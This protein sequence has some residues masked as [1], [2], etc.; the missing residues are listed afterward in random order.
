[1][2]ETLLTIV[3]ALSALALTAVFSGAE[4]G[5]YCANRLRIELGAQGR[6]PQS[7]RLARLLRDEQ[8]ILT[9]TLL[10]ATIGDYVLS[11]A[12]AFAFVELMGFSDIDSEL[13]TVAICTPVLFVFGSVV[14]KNVF[15]LYADSLMPRVAWLLVGAE[16]VLRLT[17]TLRILRGIASHAGRFAGMSTTSTALPTPRWRVANLLREALA[18]QEHGPDRSELVTR[19]VRLS[20]TPLHVVMI[21]KSDVPT[22]GAGSDREALAAVA[23]RTDHPLAPVQDD[24]GRIVGVVKVDELLK[25][26]D[27]SRVSDRLRP[28]TRLSPHNT[29][30][31]AIASL[32]AQGRSMAVV[33]DQAGRM[34]GMVTLGTLVSKVVGE[35]TRK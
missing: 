3:I 6:D 1:M 32:Q 16:R 31:A 12:V 24:A 20:E 19:V 26:Q 11:A 14:P 30:A 33:T 27:W 13:Y 5:L 23:R 29:V 17:G 15:Q 4:T 9:V 2:T 8:G 25:T 18:D 10:G 35:P 7:V 34:L 28:V 22:L 21:P